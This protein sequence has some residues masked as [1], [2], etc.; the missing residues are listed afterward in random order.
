MKKPQV[1]LE[2][3]A[4]LGEGPVWDSKNS[5]LYF[6]DIDGCTLLS[7]DYKSDKCC[8]IPAPGR[9]STALL[10]ETPGR[11]ICSIEN[12]LYIFEAETTRF[13]PFMENIYETDGTIRFN[14]GKCD[15]RGRLYVGTMDGVGK[16]RGKLFKIDVNKAIEICD[17]NIAIS[18]GLAFAGK[19]LYY[20]DSTTGFLWRYDYDIETGCLQNKTAFIDYREEKG[21][22]DGMTI[23]RDGNLWIASWGGFSVSK[24]N[25]ATGKK[26][27]MIELPVP[28]VTSCEFGGD[29]MNI[30]FITTAGGTNENMKK[31][32]PLAGSLFA[33][34]IDDVKGLEC[35]K[36]AL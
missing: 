33:V 25:S 5:V 36:F 26:L 27:D 31:D 7:Y 20:I 12:H 3:V 11:I 28:N 15:T 4:N 19:Y 22:F 8:S 34:E 1:I 29:N 6:V 17:E 24:Y 21:G 23:D 14:D 35:N 18:N 13:I 9:I 2:N 10:C 32:Y 30:L 16:S